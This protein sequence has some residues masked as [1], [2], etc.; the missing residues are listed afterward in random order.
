MTYLSAVLRLEHLGLIAGADDL[1]SSKSQS[2]NPAPQFE[3]RT[4]R[5]CLQRCR[6]AIV[7]QATLP[8]QLQ[9]G[10]QQLLPAHMPSC[11]AYGQ[12]YTPAV[13]ARQL[14]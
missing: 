11:P 10:Q 2:S 9:P 7:W 5:Q 14:A 12:Q 3:Q 8:W 6:L 13:A 4:W 1:A